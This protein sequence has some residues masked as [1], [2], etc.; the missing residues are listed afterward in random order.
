MQNALLERS[1]R[2]GPLGFYLLGLAG[3][4]IAYAFML[5]AVMQA[6]PARLIGS[7]I[8]N[9][10]PVA[11]LGLGVRAILRRFVLG[12]APLTQTGAHIVLASAF[13]LLWFWL[14]MVF[15]GVVAGRNP[16]EFEV[17]SF[18]SPAAAWQMF[19]GL[20]VYGLA[21]AL[22]YVEAMSRAARP[23]QAAA[24][25][26]DPVGFF[27][28]LG[29]DIRPLKPRDIILIRGAD[30]YSEVVT[31]SGAHLVRLSLS[32]F[33]RRLGPGFLRLHRSCLVNASEIARGEAAG[34]GRILVSLSN[35]EA[36]TTS[37]TGARLLR[38]R[39]I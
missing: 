23:E 21:A 13:S 15:L 33:A 2:A 6:A 22:T 4:V 39:V 30:D 36:V 5:G 8:A 37:R 9:V 34:G 11:L 1:W 17:R 3:L 24:A 26:D 28:R 18:P 12:R 25:N 38:D 14:L 7:A 35:G 16:V 19:Q 32:A 27:I 29:D 31:K 20:T 10:A